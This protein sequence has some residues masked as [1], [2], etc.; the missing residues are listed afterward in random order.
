MNSIEEASVSTLIVKQGEERP[1][2]TPQQ[3]VMELSPAEEAFLATIL[4]ATHHLQQGKIPDFAPQSV[5]V[6]IA[7]GWVRDKILGLETYDIDLTIDTLSGVQFAIVLQSY[8]KLTHNQI[9][10]VAVIAANPNQSKH[11]ETATM[12]VMGVDVDFCNLRAHEVY[13]DDSRIPTTRFGTPLEDAQRRDFCLNALFFNLA[14]RQVEDWTGRGIADLLQHKLLVTPLDPFVTFHDDPLRVL[15]AIR[16]A[17]RLGYQLDERIQQASKSSDVQHALLIKVSRERVGKELE[18]CLSGK[19]A[20][21]D[22]ALAL[23]GELSL[24][25]C[26]F[27]LPI[28]QLQG[29]LMG[30]PYTQSNHAA[31]WAESQSNIPLFAIVESLHKPHPDAHSML[32]RRLFALAA[33]L[34]PFRNLYYLDNK[35]KQISVIEFIIR[36]S[37]KFKNNDVKNIMTLMEHVETFVAILLEKATPLTRLRAG[38]ALRATKELWVTNLFLGAILVSPSDSSVERAQSV[39]HEIFAELELDNCWKQRPLLDGRELITVLNVPKGPVVGEYLEEQIKWMLEH[40]H[41]ARDD[42]IH[43]LEAFQ[44]TLEAKRQLEDC[45]Q[46]DG[47]KKAHLE[48]TN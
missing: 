28:C 17:I 31:A 16:F 20:K 14:T 1:A 4:E 5:Q 6:R 27:A 7:G 42:C 44:R 23:I 21:P 19:G 35:E 8:L 11:L 12:R 36:E 3:V 22:K 47:S 45:Q 40:P 43:H 48:S 30:Q 15:R 13:T 9:T 24:S 25:N 29:A 2:S 33:Y 37:L 38:L 34:L 10:K 39:Y 26:V 41:G 18:G 46:G 32:D